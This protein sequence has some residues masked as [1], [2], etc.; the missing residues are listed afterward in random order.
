MSLRLW[1]QRNLRQKMPSA[2]WSTKYRMTF[3][4]FPKVMAFLSDAIYIGGGSERERE[5]ERELFSG[6]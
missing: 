1:I 4:A 5:R 3:L 2:D 6:L